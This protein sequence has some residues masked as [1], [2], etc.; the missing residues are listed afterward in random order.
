MTEAWPA[1][2]VPPP[3]PFA[4]SEPIVARPRALMRSGP[5]LPPIMVLRR[6]AAGLDVADADVAAADA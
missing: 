4:V 5:A 1:R 2:P 3:P 6:A